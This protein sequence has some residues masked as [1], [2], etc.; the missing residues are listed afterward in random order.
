MKIQNYR[1][2]RGIAA[3][4]G[5]SMHIV[6]G[7]DEGAPTFVMRLFEIEPGGATPHHAHPWEHEMFVVSGRGAFKSGDRQTPL[8]EGDAIMALP[9]E[10]HAVIN[11]GDEMLR[12]ICVVPLVDGRMPGLPAG[13]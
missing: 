8:K 9:G 13:D 11:S 10:P 5:V 2:V 6:A 4:P 3:A 12:V 7:P 1:E